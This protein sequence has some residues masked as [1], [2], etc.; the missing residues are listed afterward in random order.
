[1]LWHGWPAVRVS[2][3]GRFATVYPPAV[4]AANFAFYGGG[5]SADATRLLDEY[6]A[7]MVLA[8]AGWRTPAHGR[9]GWEVRYRDE[10]AELLMTGLATAPTVAR[11]VEGRLRFP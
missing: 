1:V 5:P 8:P 9:P 4:V 10:V 7:T 11:A 3:D 6:R 2:L